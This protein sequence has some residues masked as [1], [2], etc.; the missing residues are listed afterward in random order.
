[1]ASYTD[2]IPQF[3]PYV[4]ELPIQAMVE[5]GMEKQR[6]YDEGVQKIQQSIQNVAGLEVGNDASRE[7]LQSQLNNLGSRLRSFAGSDFS[8]YQLVNSVSGM[9]TQLVKDPFIKAGAQ[10]AANIKK[11]QQFIDEEKKNGKLGVSNLIGYQKRLNQYMTSGLK[12]DEGKPIIFSYDYKQF[13]DVDKFTKEQFDTLKPDKY[14]Y[15]DVFTTDP[16]TG[17]KTLSPAMIKLKREG[18]FPKRVE[19]V[20]DQIFSDPRVKQQLQLDG[21]YNFGNYSSDELIKRVQGIKDAR[22]K[23]YDDAILELNAKKT[24]GEDVS[25][26]IDKMTELRDQV[27]NNFKGIIDSS[28]TNPDAVRGFLEVEDTRDNYRGMYTYVQEDRDVTEN[29]YYKAQWEREKF[30]TEMNWDKYKFEEGLKEK[31]KDRDLS[32]ALAR[33]KNNKGAG[34]DLNG[35]GIPD[36]S[37]TFGVGVMQAPFE[38]ENANVVAQYDQIVENDTKTYRS[39]VDN[40]IFGSV[41]NT[42]GNQALINKMVAGNNTP[43][44]S[45]EDKI[46][47]AKQV[48][49]D[50]TAK[51]NGETPEAFRTRWYTKSLDFLGKNPSKLSPAVRNLVTSAGAA[52]DKFDQTMES[53]KDVNSLGKSDLEKILKNTKTIDYDFTLPISIEGFKNMMTGKTSTRKVTPQMQLD[54]ALVIAGDNVLQTKELRNEAAAARKRLAAQGI[55]DDMAFTFVND[56]IG[57]GIIPAKISG[58][59]IAGERAARAIGLG[60][61]TLTPELT[62]LSSSA[63][64]PPSIKKDKNKSNFYNVIRGVYNP[65]LTRSFDQKAA[66]IKELFP[67]N[68][69]L[70]SSVLTGNAE[71]DRAIKDN[72]QA[73]IGAYVKSG[74]NESPD[75]MKN[76]PAMGKIL[77]GEGKGSFKIQSRKDPVTK[78]VSS[79]LQFYNE[80][81]QPIGEV[82]I[83]ARQAAAIGK[84]PSNWFMT[85]GVNQVMTKF[86]LSGNGTTSRRG[87]LTDPSVYRTNDALGKNYF[88]NLRGYPGD[89]KANMLAQ[90]SVDQFGTPYTS[91]FVYMYVYDNDTMKKPVIK[92]LKREFY[93]IDE[94]LDVMNKLTPQAVELLKAEQ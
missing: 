76:A 46:Q 41:L 80:S 14:T 15:T 44:L 91:Y 1:M 42:P 29:P 27:N 93:S 86:K 7:Y 65:Q 36:V 54:M 20:L 64:P 12:D 2:K 32:I 53:V 87:D 47:L 63:E 70:E 8:N 22:I 71:A 72:V 92:P 84:D 79:V 6:R 51:K 68:P 77:S 69:V 35:D 13:F 61:I 9:T 58:L 59:Q 26:Q 62:R 11:Q 60:G 30:A 17:K 40:L 38:N 49:I 28:S 3:N 25:K 74:M 4:Q 55:D 81:L 78:Q 33:L 16:T 56:M 5:V 67:I 18:M 23:E 39:S 88:G 82:T 21:E 73:I 50:S 52:A 83:D 31:Q 94:A 43:G 24:A 37:S 57:G 75:F 45:Q 89:I 19:E 66:K 48:L 34:I 85:E 90:Q 10:S